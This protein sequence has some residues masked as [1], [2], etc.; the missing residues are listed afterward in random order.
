MNL[1][2]LTLPEPRIAR[3]EKLA[4]G[5]FIHW[6][7]YSLL[8]TGEWFR[9]L[10][11]M[12]HEE[13]DALITKFTAEDF[14][15]RAIAKLAREAGMRYIVLTTRHHDGFS[16]YD[17][18]G[19]SKHDTLHS[20]AGRDLVAEF[21][22]GCRA[23][24]IVPFLYHT[25][26]D[27]RWKSHTCSAEDFLKYLDYL[28]A[29]VEILC[30]HYG[31]IGGIWFDGHWSRKD[32]DWQE[33]RLYKMIR[34]LQPEA[35]IINNSG[36]ADPGKPGHREL[37][38]VTFEQGLPKAIDHRGKPKYL[39]AE[40]CQT[41][42]SHWGI[43]AHDYNYLSPAQIIET[44]S[45]ARGAGANYLLNVGPTGSGSIPAY[46]AIALQRAGKWVASHAEAVYGGKPVSCRCQGRD[47]V[48]ES[49]GIFYYFAFN[50]Q[51]TGHA[52]VSLGT[53]GAGPRAV[54]ALPGTIQ[55]ASWMDNGESLHF[56]Q[57]ADL[58]LIDLTGY[59]YGTNLVVRVVR[60]EAIL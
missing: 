36:L 49:G 28:N 17:T 23:E 26:L 12:P 46:E 19:L 55:S 16:L 7:L 15:A 10:G 50:L 3:F 44:L 18:R 29:S 25:T 52:Q 30:T 5:M 39:A 42:N 47:F 48:L 13:Y 27:W 6:G 60:I 38:T 4:Y 11:T 57:D 34:R 21:V 58:T 2:P 22:D 35:L 41:F 8:G 32:L 59:P 40:M 31:E 24:G 54:K 20:P 37:D 1:P 43:G 56:I 9:H 14:D 51:V 53:G 45:L 33:D